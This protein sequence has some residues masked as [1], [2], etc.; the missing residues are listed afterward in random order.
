MCGVEMFPSPN[1]FIKGA[2]VLTR[3]LSAAS[4]DAA[5]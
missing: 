1:Q 3:L 4:I 2:I 5:L